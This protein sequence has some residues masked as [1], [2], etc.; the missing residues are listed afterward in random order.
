VD[1]LA[2]SLEKQ[3]AIVTELGAI[4]KDL[5]SGLID[6]PARVNDREG[7][8]CW[9]LEEPS[10]THWHGLTEGFGGRK[11]LKDEEKK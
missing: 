10:I 1:F 4:P 9:K 11:P 5:E 8:L 7:Y 6:F 2:A 3:L